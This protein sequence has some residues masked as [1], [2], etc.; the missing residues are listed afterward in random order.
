MAPRHPPRALCSLTPSAT[1]RQA[2]ARGCS[3]DHH[4]VIKRQKLKISI[5]L[6]MSHLHLERCRAPWAHVRRSADPSSDPLVGDLRPSGRSPRIRGSPRVDTQRRLEHGPEPS[7]GQRVWEARSLR[8]LPDIHLVYVEP[9]QCR[10]LDGPPISV[11]GGGDEET[12]TPDPLLAKEMLFQLSYVP[13]PVGRGLGER[14]GWWAFLD[15]N[16]RPLP[17]QGSALTS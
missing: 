16:Q 11:L 13:L 14:V 7:V 6:P 8:G 17:Y 4:L 5:N 2:V 9:A 10:S 15:S 12:R 3:R 1:H